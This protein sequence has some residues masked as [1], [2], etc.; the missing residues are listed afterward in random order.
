MWNGYMNNVHPGSDLYESPVSWC[1]FSSGI[2]S[3]RYTIFYENAYITSQ[4][5]AGENKAELVVNHQPS[6]LWKITPRLS[7]YFVHCHSGDSRRA[8]TT[9]VSNHILPSAP[10]VTAEYT[11]GRSG[12]FPSKLLS[13]LFQS[14]GAIL[15]VHSRGFSVVSELLSGL[16]ELREISFKAEISTV[17]VAKKTKKKKKI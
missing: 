1:Q 13:G 14:T 6:I 2:M 17:W 10:A 4:A 8:V 5:W 12:V 16:S 7:V 9:I 15:R 3:L 11:A